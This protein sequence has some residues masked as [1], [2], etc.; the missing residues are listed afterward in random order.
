MNDQEVGRTPLDVEFLY[1][2]TYDVRLELDGYE[3]LWTAGEANAPWWDTPGADFVSELMPWEARSDVAWHY[4]LE[5]T[6]DDPAGLVDR[7]RAL[8]QRAL[9]AEPALDSAPPEGP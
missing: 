2:G 8:R 1:Y 7:A 5:P 9:E 3:T 6:I 4:E